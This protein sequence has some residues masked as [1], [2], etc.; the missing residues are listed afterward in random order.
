MSQQQTASEVPV[1][2]VGAGPAGLMMASALVKFLVDRGHTVFMI[3]WRNPGAGTA[4]S[5]WPTISITA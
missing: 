2:V 5:A 4:I 3:S 1:L